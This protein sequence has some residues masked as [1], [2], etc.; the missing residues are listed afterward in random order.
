M[1]H[2]MKSGWQRDPYSYSFYLLLLS[3]FYFL[4]VVL[5]YSLVVGRVDR[6]VFKEK[7]QLGRY[8]N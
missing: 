5:L 4:P 1:Q 8:C 3:F 7:T 6:V 2:H